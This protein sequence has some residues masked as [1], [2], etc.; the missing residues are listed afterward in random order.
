[1]LQ[2][3]QD[4]TKASHSVRNLRSAG[5][6]NHRR[7]KLVQLWVILLLLG[8]FGAAG[9]RGTEPPASLASPP[10]LS[11][12][13]AQSILAESW[14]AYQQRFIQGDG[15]VID[16]E[17][18]DRTVSE[19]QAYAMLRAVLIDDPDTFERTLNWAESNLRQ[20]RPDGQVSSQL[21]AWKWG[22]QETGEWGV[23]D[24]NF[25][26]DADIDTAFALILAARRWQRSDYLE[27][28]RAKLAE[29]WAESTVEVKG[30]RYLLPGPAVA[31]QT[32]THVYL[33]PSYLAPYAFRVFA[34]V[35]RDRDWMQLVDSSYRMLEKSADLSDLKLPGDWV[36]LNIDSGRFE[37]IP[38]SS[39]S[40]LKNQY[41]FDA[42]RVWWRIAWDEAL[43][44][45]RPARKYLR[46]H[47]RP[48]Q[49][50]WLAD[51]MIPAEFDLAGQPLVEYD[52]IA[53]YAM[54]Y[55]GWQ[56]INPAIAADVYQ[57]KITP[58]YQAGI[59]DNESAYYS[60]N[61]VWFAL[62]PTAEV[63]TLLQAP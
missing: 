3:T 63:Q 25:A 49:E 47:M 19:G 37:P 44:D 59:W 6:L 5:R 55:I 24:A 57:R 10:A 30:R 40:D 26:S 38:A 20:R 8:T 16:F 42:Y 28:A 58:Q 31:F 60:Q 29:L 41:G 46:D 50:M 23:I 34:E 11:E 54:L 61:L 4:W 2:P 36:A 1:M 7:P 48:L 17:A 32:D 15:R 18:G 51:Q 39:D 21:W 53:Q 14:Q 45:A 33:N 12:A 13:E 27:L 62:F 52:T 56:V 35:D 22:Q 43:F 9:C